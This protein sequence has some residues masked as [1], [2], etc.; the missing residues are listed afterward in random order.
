MFLNPEQFSAF[1][2]SA[3]NVEMPTS[4]SLPARRK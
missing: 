3:L 2:D 1:G 4:I